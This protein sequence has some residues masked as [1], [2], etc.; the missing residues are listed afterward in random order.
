MFSK[1]IQSTIEEDFQIAKERLEGR[2]DALFSVFTDANEEELLCLKYIY[3]YLPLSD[4]ANYD[5]QLFLKLVR[6]AI[7]ARNIFSWG[8]AMPEDIFLNYVLAVRINNE[9]LT[10][11]RSI[12]LDELQ[13]RIGHLDLEDAV[14]EVN[15]WCYEKATYQSTDSRTVSPLTIVRRAFGR[16]GE[17]STFTVSALRSVGIAARQCYTP[18][19]AHSDDNHAWVEVWIDGSWH[20]LG[21]CEPEAVLNK[22]WF[23]QPAR[24]GMLIE[25]RIFSSLLGEEKVVK[26][27]SGMTLINVSD[28]YFPSVQLRIKIKDHG[29]ICSGVDVDFCVLNYASMAAIVR[30]TTDDQGEVSFECGQGDLFVRAMKGSMYLEKKVS[31]QDGDLEVVMDFRD[32]D[33]NKS[34]DLYMKAPQDVAIEEQFVDPTL[35]A[36]LEIKKHAAEE[37]RIA[38]IET[39]YSEPDPDRPDKGSLA[40][41]RDKALADSLGNHE[42][43]KHFLDEQESGFDLAIKLDL[44]EALNYKDL[45]DITADICLHHLEAAAIFKDDYPKEV[46]NTSLLNPRIGMEMISK[47]RM[48]TNYFDEALL[49]GFRQNP[50]RI[51]DYIN[52]N[53][54]DAGDLDYQTIMANPV[55]L[56]ELGIGSHLSRRI[57]TIAMARS[58]GIPARI[59]REDYHLEYFKDNSWLRF[60]GEQDIAL[61]HIRSAKLTLKKEDLEEAIEYGTHLS[62]ARLNQNGVFDTL[63]YYGQAFD[64]DGLSLFHLEPGMYQ[65]LLCRRLP[66][67]DMLA[68]VERFSLDAHTDLVKTISLPVD[69]TVKK[70]YAFELLGLAD[71]FY[72][73]G[74][75]RLVLALLQPAAE[76]T[77]HFLNECLDHSDLVE[78]VQASMT[79]VL[80]S[81]EEL[82]NPKL[83][84]VLERFPKIKLKYIEDEGRFDSYVEDSFNAYELT[85]RQ[86]PLLVNTNAAGKVELA[87]SGYQVGS[88]AMLLDSL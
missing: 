79:F 43:I 40:W 58:L 41:R 67:G 14:L 3:S 23:S 1:M 22:G 28:L 69:D 71:G 54:K 16:C 47:W 32:A 19:W 83:Q 8:R 25:S 7:K 21:A 53:I 66:S 18:R 73:V 78:A 13:A 31:L 61:E 45:S 9:D 42:E 88:V 35:E 4:L 87:I 65:L 85:N 12:F 55:G 84:M 62:L 77:E 11:H 38:F 27:G 39:F 74:Q 64:E 2:Q 46:F 52:S 17:E 72:E 63:A 57:F 49:D 30:L 86:L 37:K 29:E 56:Y 15:L 6:D 81:A 20:Y 26:Q 50:V 51:W 76:P 10:D 33:P 82:D 48:L 80:R 34:F 5:G 68:K 70:S 60:T 59:N 44:L 36:E 75:E 24:R